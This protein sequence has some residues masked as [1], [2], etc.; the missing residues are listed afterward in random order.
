MI[1]SIA[2]IV[3]ERIS[4]TTDDLQGGDSESEAII[5][6]VQDAYSEITKRIA[7]GEKVGA[8]RLNDLQNEIDSLNEQMLNNCDKLSQEATRNNAFIFSLQEIRQC[9][10]DLNELVS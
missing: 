3:I 2:S 10:E 8:S 4:N 1:G 7:E 9:L 5:R 6:D